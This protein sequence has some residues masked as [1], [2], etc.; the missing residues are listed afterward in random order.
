MTD[1]EFDKWL[2]DSNVFVSK[3]K[4][5]LLVDNWGFYILPSPNYFLFP[6]FFYLKSKYAVEFGVTFA[7]FIFEVQNNR[8]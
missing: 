3:P 1:K 2:D 4:F 5:K 6:R 7:G 8:L